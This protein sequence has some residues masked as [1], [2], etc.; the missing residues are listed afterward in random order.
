MECK[1]QIQ[2]H[3]ECEYAFWLCD[4]M[5]LSSLMTSGQDLEPCY[6]NDTTEKSY[7]KK[8]NTRILF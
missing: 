6:D 1:C 3:V 7:D 8:Q 5:P 4:V 2:L